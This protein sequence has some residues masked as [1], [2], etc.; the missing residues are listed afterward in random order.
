MNKIFDLKKAQKGAQQILGFNVKK[1]E[2]LAII[3]SIDVDPNYY[4]ILMNV[5]KDMGV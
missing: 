1:G 4:K 3:G 2:T 5:A